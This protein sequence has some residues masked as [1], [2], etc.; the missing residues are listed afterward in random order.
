MRIVLSLVCVASACVACGC[1]GHS[2]HSASFTQP[3]AVV[4]DAVRE[5]LPN[6]YL[7]VS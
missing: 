1:A 5:S 6:D 2:I 7:R 4:S 3:P